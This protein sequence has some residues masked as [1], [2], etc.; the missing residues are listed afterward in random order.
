MRSSGLSRP[1]TGYVLGIAL[2]S[3]VLF[4]MSPWPASANGPVGAKTAGMGTVF[5]AVADDPST[6]AF[7]P[8]GLTN[9][10]GTQVY[11]GLVAVLT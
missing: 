4:L 7:N 1:A 5:T 9:C 2:I 11:A 3:I 10:T 8:A 6:I